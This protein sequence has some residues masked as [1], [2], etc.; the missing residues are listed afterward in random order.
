MVASTS[1]E[2]LENLQHSM[3]RFREKKIKHCIKSYW[4]TNESK[5]RVDATKCNSMEM[6]PS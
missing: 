4:L 3:R 2:M 6:N 1:P 5:L